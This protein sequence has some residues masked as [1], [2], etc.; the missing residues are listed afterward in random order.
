MATSTD[1]SNVTLTA[2]STSGKVSG[3]VSGN[4]VTTTT[5]DPEL[6]H[7]HVDL[8]TPS[9]AVGAL[10]KDVT[11]QKPATSANEAATITKVTDSSGRTYTIAADGKSFTSN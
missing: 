8:S 5:F 7:V 9:G 2:T 1:F 4:A 11:V 3:S 10:D 6:V